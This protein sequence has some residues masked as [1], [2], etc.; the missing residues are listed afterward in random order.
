MRLVT[1]NEM[2]QL[3]RAAIDEFGIPGIVLMENAGRGTAEAILARFEGQCED[4]VVILCGPGNNGGDG[5]VIARHLS[6]EDYDVQCLLVGSADKLTGDAA[7]NHAIVERLGIPVIQIQTEEEAEVAADEFD[8]AGVIVDALFGTGLTRAIEGPAALLIERV[9]AQS[10]PIVAVD[11]P[12]GISSDTGKP[13]GPAVFADLT[14]TL[15]LPKLGHYLYPGPDHCGEVVVIDISLPP[16]LLDR[17]EPRAWTV[18]AIDIAPSFLPRNEDTHK[19]TYGHVMI[20]G[21][22]RGMTGAAALAADAAVLSGA[23]LVTIA[24]P[25]PSLPTMEVLCTE[26]L[27]A[28]LAADADGKLAA[29]A[30]AGALEMAAGKSVVAFGPGLGQSAALRELAAAFVAQATVPLV[31]DADGLNN[32]AGNLGVLADANVPLVLTPHPGE[33]AL[34]L[35]TD[36]ATVQNDRP[37][38]A[39]ELAKRTGAVVALKGAATIIAVPTGEIWINT[40]GNPGMASGGT[41]DVLT[42]LIAGLI[43]QGLET[44]EATVAGVFIHGAAGDSAAEETGVR[45]LTA[46]AIVDAIPTVIEAFEALFDAPDALTEDDE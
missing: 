33:M 1:A 22:S 7:T 31:I 27:K 21:G 46:T 9:L 5:F 24:V 41:G 38:A 8:E 17:F 42:G 16:D 3:D 2:R 29:D 37:G 36:T 18:D 10:A 30:L 44:L 6:N 4:G 14:C 39:R 26:A 15:G 35:G 11:I 25:A 19:G 34:L 12:S 40:T 32:L 43:A 13:T 20:L 28:P 45:G 23:G